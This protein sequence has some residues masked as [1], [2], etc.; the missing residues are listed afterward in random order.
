[1]AKEASL[2]IEGHKGL[3]YLKNLCSQADRVLDIGC[4]EGTRLN[5]LLSRNKS[6]YGVDINPYA[7]SLAKKQYPHHKFYLSKSGSLPF[8][9]NSFDIVYSAFVLEHTSDPEIFIKEMVRVCKIQ[10]KIVVLCPNY[11]SPNR[12]SPISQENPYSK[13]IN[14]T[15]NDFMLLLSKNLVRLNWKQVNPRQE[16]LH[17]DDDTTLEPYIH[18]LIKFLETEKIIIEKCSSLWEKENPSLNPRKVL[19]YLLGRLN[20]FPFKY[21]GPQLFIVGKK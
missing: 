12:R 13:F 21:W 14:G 5:T 1:M 20:I 8:G 18:S 15:I 19:T 2:Q 16:Y 3:E 7:I 4:G 11:G 10:G 17:Q 9:S 6:G